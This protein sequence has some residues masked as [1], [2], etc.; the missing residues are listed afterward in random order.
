M[1]RSRQHILGNKCLL[2]LFL[3]SNEI[4]LIRLTKPQA[5][6][7]PA[8]REGRDEEEKRAES[9]ATRPEQEEGGPA[10]INDNEV[11]VV[12][13]QPVVMEPGLERGDQDRKVATNLVHEK[14]EHSKE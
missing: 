2:F 5:Q 13:V 12:T 4:L 8:G 3:L 1:L 11:G 9:K 7:L 14:Q 6:L 10:L